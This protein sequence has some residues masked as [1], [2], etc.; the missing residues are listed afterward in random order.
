MSGSFQE[1]P[2]VPIRRVYF[3][4]I[5]NQ[6]KTLE[7]V[8]FMKIFKFFDFQRVTTATYCQMNLMARFL[9]CQKR[10]SIEIFIEMHEELQLIHHVK[11]SPAREHLHHVIGM[12][13]PW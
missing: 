9:V 10:I 8:H 13:K 3:R 6:I 12:G 5:I 7:K 1:S 4:Y 11:I 2:Y